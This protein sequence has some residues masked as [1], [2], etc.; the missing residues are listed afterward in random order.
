MFQV[1]KNFSIE[2]TSVG[3][4]Y[5]LFFKNGGL[6]YSI[7]N[8]V[9]WYKNN[10]S[11]LEDL[12]ILTITDGCNKAISQSNLDKEL[13]HALNSCHDVLKKKVLTINKKI[14]I[15]DERFQLL[16]NPI[17]LTPAETKLPLWKI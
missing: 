11:K 10:S 13:W 17:G 8:L 14:V 4:M 1:I 9:N 6:L 2:N 5:S 3:M 12:E 15:E 7:K 16:S